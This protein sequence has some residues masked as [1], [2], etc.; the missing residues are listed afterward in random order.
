MCLYLS[1]WFLIHPYK[2]LCILMDSIGSLWL[3]GVLIGPYASLCVLMCPYWSLSVL[4][5]PYASLC[6][7]MGT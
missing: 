5:G 3:L 7:F 1:L 6:I 2:F 4:I